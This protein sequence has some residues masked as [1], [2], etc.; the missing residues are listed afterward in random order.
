[1]AD[2][3]IL[4]TYEEGDAITIMKPFIDPFAKFGE[5]S[6]DDSQDNKFIKQ[7]YHLVCC[8]PTIDLRTKFQNGL[9]DRMLLRYIVYDQ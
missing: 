9:P 3:K 6:Q 2:P 1:M 7:M 4:V 8:E 5:H